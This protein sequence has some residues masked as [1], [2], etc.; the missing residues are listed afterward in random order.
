MS[1]S[2]SDQL[3]RA[4]S[5][6]L[7]SLIPT[8]EAQTDQEVKQQYGRPSRKDKDNKTAPSA[9]KGTKPGE[10]RKTYLVEIEAADQIEAV[11]YWD[12]KSVKEVVGEAFASYLERYIKKNG[13]IEPKPAK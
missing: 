11:A 12:R 1:K 10:M 5:K 13:S 9:E 4:S 6:G 7:S 8:E 2:F 3:K